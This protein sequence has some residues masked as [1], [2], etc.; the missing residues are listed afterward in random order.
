MPVYEACKA[1]V[2][3]QNSVRP[4]SRDLR[5]LNR[6]IFFKRTRYCRD[7]GEFV[8]PMPWQSRAGSVEPL[9]RFLWQECTTETHIRAATY[10]EVL[11]GL[12]TSTL[13]E[14]EP[15]AVIA[16]DA[17]YCEASYSDEFLN[18][19][20]LVLLDDLKIA[21]ILTWAFDIPE[22]ESGHM[23]DGKFAVNV[24]STR[25]LK[26]QDCFFSVILVGARL[27]DVMTYAS[28]IFGSP[29]WTWDEDE[30]TKWFGFDMTRVAGF[31]QRE[32]VLPGF[33]AGVLRKLPGMSSVMYHIPFHFFEPSP[34]LPSLMH[35]L[36]PEYVPTPES[37]YMSSPEYVPGIWE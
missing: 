5:R 32:E 12:P 15:L 35:G 16:M 6:L 4:S 24:G 9:L 34:S 26:H 27:A 31:E 10:V 22:N 2:A 25:W 11:G 37:E 36:S 17:V 28:Q 3:T 30:L 14:R 20:A 7:T 1:M 21:L 23:L 33:G 13:Q 8:P 18:V 19:A 29:A